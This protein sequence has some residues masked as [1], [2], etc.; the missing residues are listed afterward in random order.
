MHRTE[1][2]RGHRK[3]HEVVTKDCLE[4]LDSLKDGCANLAITDPPYNL[5]VAEWDMFSSHKEFLDF[6]FGWLDALIPKLKETG[7]LYVFNTP[8]TR[9]SYYNTYARWVWCSKIG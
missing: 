3:L 6:T 8:S 2:D 5:K 9:P 7:S 1:V 4:F